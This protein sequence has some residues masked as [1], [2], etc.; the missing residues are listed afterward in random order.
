MNGPACLWVAA[1]VSLAN[2]QRVKL[3]GSATLD[4]GSSSQ[5]QFRWGLFNDATAGR[6]SMA[7]NC[8]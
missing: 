3:T 5:E 2:G 8:T 1:D 7:L 6:E 4:G